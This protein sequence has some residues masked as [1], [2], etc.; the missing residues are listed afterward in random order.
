MKWNT[1]RETLSLKKTKEPVGSVPEGEVFLHVD[2]EDQMEFDA[3]G[4]WNAVW[5]VKVAESAAA[6]ARIHALKVRFGKKVVLSLLSSS[7]DVVADLAREGQILRR[8]MRRISNAERWT[9]TN[10]N[11]HL[12]ER[13]NAVCGLDSQDM[14]TPNGVVSVEEWL[15]DLEDRV[16]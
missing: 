9:Q 11:K 2:L 16:F 13:V 1:I 10:F 4:R 7:S 14:W 12:K 5:Q 15:A 6:S 3:M 8:Q